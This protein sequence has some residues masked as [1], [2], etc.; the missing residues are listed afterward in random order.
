MTKLQ[1]NWYAENLTEWKN[2]LNVKKDIQFSVYELSRKVV[3]FERRFDATRAEKHAVLRVLIKNVTQID[4]VMYPKGPGSDLNYMI[5]IDGKT[6]VDVRFNKY[7]QNGKYYPNPLALYLEHIVNYLHHPL[8]HTES[9][10][11]VDKMVE[12]NIS[13]E[14]FQFVQ[15]KVHPFTTD[16][17]TFERTAVINPERYINHSQVGIKSSVYG[18]NYI[19]NIGSTIICVLDTVRE[20]KPQMHVLD[21]YNCKRIPVSLANGMS[22]PVDSESV[23]R[24]MIYNLSLI[25]KDIRE[26]FTEPYRASYLDWLTGDSL[27]SPTFCIATDI[28]QHYRDSSSSLHELS[29]AIHR[30][31]SDNVLIP[32]V[33]STQVIKTGSDIAEQVLISLNENNTN[34]PFVV[35]KIDS[36]LDAKQNKIIVSVELTRRYN[37]Q[38]G[39]FDGDFKE[40]AVDYIRHVSKYMRGEYKDRDIT[41]VE[42]SDHSDACDFLRKELSESVLKTRKEYLTRIANAAEFAY[43][44]DTMTDGCKKYVKELIGGMV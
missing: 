37:L 6:R 5:D 31:S 22:V 27:N 14:C 17:N 19:M 44:S 1:D 23:K 26:D 15:R 4:F 25:W 41:H 8:T 28:P 35:K 13:L 12:E 9:A 3:L 39:K 42:Y 7:P 16:T 38:V 40:M 11:I 18:P 32:T 2:G 30:D 33:S 20:S 29:K 24:I 36:V 21:V 10:R 34:D 43:C